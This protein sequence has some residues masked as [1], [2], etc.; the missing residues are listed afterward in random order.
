MERAA[1][2]MTPIWVL[3]PVWATVTP[4]ALPSRP[5]CA[6]TLPSGP[7]ALRVLD[8]VVDLAVGQSDDG[9]LGAG[10]GDGDLGEVAQGAG[11]G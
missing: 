9:D 4:V 8:V 6:V 11:L 3:S 2:A 5:S 1:S 7:L 10:G